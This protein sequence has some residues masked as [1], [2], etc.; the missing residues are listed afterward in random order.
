MSI[1]PFTTVTGV[2]APL[3][4][5]NIDTDVI[6]P[7]Q[8]LKGITRNDLARGV[9]YDLWFDESGHAREDFILN[10]APYRESRF[11]IVGPNFGCG[12]SREH[13]VWGLMQ[14]GIRAI[15]GTSFA[16]IFHDNCFRNGLLA[17]ALP[18]RQLEQMQ[19]L[20]S[21]PSQSSLG[22]DLRTEI[23]TLAD[24]ARIPFKVDALRRDDLLNGRDPIASTLRFSADI[25]EFENR[26]WAANP[27]LKPR[28][29]A[30]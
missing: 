23:I 6:M 4:A 19:S 16:S 27:W 15:L 20:C 26:H 3:P 28:E 12:S 1:E 29:P 17:V 18:A 30:T 22:V 13:A 21:D 2:A 9:F 8:F 5:A 14:F 10:R 24:G 7:K 11:L 25:Q